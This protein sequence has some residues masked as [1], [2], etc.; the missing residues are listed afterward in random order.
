MSDINCFGRPSF[1]PDDPQ[2]HLTKFSF[3]SLIFFFFA[4]VFSNSLCQP[5]F[6]CHQKLQHNFMTPENFRKIGHSK[7]SLCLSLS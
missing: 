5:E 2:E 4:V 7:N 1:L 6:P 3:S